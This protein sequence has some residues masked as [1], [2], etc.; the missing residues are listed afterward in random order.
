[1]KKLFSLLLASMLLFS[2]CSS[3]ES[4]P[5]TS[6]SAGEETTQTST[7]PAV[8]AEGNSGELPADGPDIQLDLAHNSTETSIYH[9]V[10]LQFKETLESRSGGK[11][12]LNVYPN[13]QLGSD[14]EIAASCQ[15][16][17]ISMVY[18][19]SSTHATL[20]PEASLFDTPFLLTNYSMDAVEQVCI[21]SAFREKYNA[22]YDA[23]GFKLMTLSAVNTMN[24]S[25][26]KAIE[27][28]ADLQGLK[29]RTAQSESRMA[30]WTA[31]GANPTPL[32]YSELYMA[33]QQ[34][35][36]TASD[37]TFSNMVSGKLV[38][39]QKY[40]FKSA[41]FQPSFCLLMNKSKFEELPKEYQDLIEAVSRENNYIEFVELEK[42]EQEC[43]RIISEEYGLEFCEI[44]DSFMVEMQ[45]KAKPAV[46]SARKLVNNDD[47]F[48]QLLADL[49]AAK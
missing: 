12:K 49:E 35:L 7:Q 4:T 3:P 9:A 22:V 14:S 1:M 20:V 48:D 17:N 34:G 33:L 13:G 40:V 46:E 29:I 44:S 25:S 2:G 28:M 10:I 15:L 6:G 18:Q 36:V 38:E 41:H 30:I 8:S 5:A 16:G 21:D 19:S 23:A 31:L 11:I 45:V 37:N 39:Q 43:E 47:L 32:A 27:S 26:N 24:L 42:D